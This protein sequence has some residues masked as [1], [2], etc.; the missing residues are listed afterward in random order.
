MRRRRSLPPDIIR[1]L[2]DYLPNNSDLSWHLDWLVVEQPFQVLQAIW[3]CP[4]P[5]SIQAVEQLTHVLQLSAE[6]KGNQQG[7]QHLPYYC[8]WITGYDFSALDPESASQ[9]TVANLTTILTVPKLPLEILNT[10]HCIALVSTLV[11][12]HIESLRELNYHHVHSFH[13]QL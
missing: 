8:A 1:V 9:L 10:S 11:S 6:P 7:S 12:R 2:V 3:K 13:Q 5:T 4:R